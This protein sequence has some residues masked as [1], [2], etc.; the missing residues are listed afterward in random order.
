[1]AKLKIKFKICKLNQNF[2]TQHR[3]ILKHIMMTSCDILIVTSFAWGLISLVMIRSRISFQFLPSCF[4][5]LPLLPP[6][7]RFWF[8]SGGLSRREKER[9]RE[10]EREREQEGGMK[11]GLREVTHSFWRQ[12]TNKYRESAESRCC[13]RSDFK[14]TSLPNK[15]GKRDVLQ[16]SL[17][18]FVLLSYQPLIGCINTL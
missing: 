10:R 9:K 5:C 3:Y 8:G 18:S 16:S 7:L 1:M 17:S 13:N 11:G 14:N 12:K 2:Y 15:T 6:P 4:S